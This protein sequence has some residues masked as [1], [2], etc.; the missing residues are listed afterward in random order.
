MG[1]MMVIGS[2]IE[3]LGSRDPQ[4]LVLLCPFSWF[5]GSVCFMSLLKACLWRMR[6]KYRHHQWCSA[7][8][9][10]SAT[11]IAVYCCIKIQLHNIRLYLMGVYWVL[12]HLNQV[13][14]FAFEKA[15][16]SG[17][18]TPPPFQPQKKLRVLR[19]SDN[20]GRDPRDWRPATGDGSVS[21]CF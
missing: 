14:S 15:D 7:W 17:R 10:H 16:I 12:I 3:D 13:D 9:N 8:V 18:K 6:F 19:R 4:C 1:Y 21:F 20:S 2:E 11:G 5:L